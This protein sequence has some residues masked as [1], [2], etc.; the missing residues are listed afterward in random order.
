ML[1]WILMGGAAG[2]VGG[3][4]MGG[5]TLLIP[6]LT[7]L[8]G[9]EQ[10]MAQAINLLVFLPTG[11]I[12]LI[13]H[14]KNKLVDFRLFFCVAPIALAVAIGFSILALNLKSAILS[15][16]FGG[17]L[18]FIGIILLVRAIKSKN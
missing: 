12:A 11:L 16:L 8:G 4:G 5:G 2:I 14:I 15:H 13:L 17:F 6:L 7:L 18:I 3:M 9:V 1:W 10:H